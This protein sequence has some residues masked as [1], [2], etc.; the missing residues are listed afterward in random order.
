VVARRVFAGMPPPFRDAFA[1]EK[2]KKTLG[3]GRLELE[4][5]PELVVQQLIALLPLLSAPHATA[6]PTTPLA[7]YAV[8]RPL[9]F[10]HGFFSI[11]FFSP[12]GCFDTRHVIFIL[13]F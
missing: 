8:T 6:A 9:F 3:P 13:P 2:T 11:Y 10:L 1:P 7:R 12:G 5:S 4:H